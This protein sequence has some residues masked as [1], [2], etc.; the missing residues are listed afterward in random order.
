MIIP[1]YQRERSIDD[2]IDS[3]E[4]SRLSNLLADT[5]APNPLDHLYHKEI[6]SI[7]SEVMVVLTVRE[8]TILEDRYGLTGEEEMTLEAIGQKLGLS[9]ER[10][11]QLER[12]AKQKL[13]QLLQPRRSELCHSL[14]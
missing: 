6:T 7:I 13:L 5:D 3:G 14:A 10:V 12:D 8:R 4:E 11:R 2:F 1:F 9:R